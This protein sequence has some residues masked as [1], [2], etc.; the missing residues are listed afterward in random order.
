MERVAETAPAKALVGVMAVIAGTAVRT[1]KETGVEPPP[2]GKGF[3]TLIDTGPGVRRSEESR[4]TFNDV[5]LRKVVVR[6]LL[7]TNTVDCATKLRP[8]KFTNKPGAP[9][10]AVLGFMP[11]TAGTPLATGVIVNI[12]PAGAAWF[13]A[14]NVP[15]PGCGVVTVMKRVFGFWSRLAWR[16][17][18]ISFVLIN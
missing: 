16:M 6:L 4:S 17:T 2:P 13:C 18:I 14:G 11:V 15:P 3:T 7:F 9:A 12:V 5:E 10:K 8:V 1:F